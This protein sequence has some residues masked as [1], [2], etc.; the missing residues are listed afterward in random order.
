M[1]QAKAL[2][3]SSVVEALP[4]V[5]IEALAM[6]LRIVATDCP[7]RTARDSLRGSYGKLVPV[8]NSELMAESIV[9]VLRAANIPAIP[10]RALERF[11]QDRVIEQYLSVIGVMRPGTR[12]NWTRTQC[13]F[14]S[15]LKARAASDRGRASYESVVLVSVL[16]NGPKA[17]SPTV[18]LEARK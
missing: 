13:R 15:T 9:N 17:C 14:H 7:T 16:L 6:N 1:K 3:L 11:Q 5:L 8:G 2:A 4:T 18:G 10:A 12:H